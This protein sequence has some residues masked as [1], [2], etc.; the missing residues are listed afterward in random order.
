MACP[1]HHAALEREAW[2]EE[3]TELEENE[4]AGFQTSD[5]TLASGKNDLEAY[6][7][8]TPPASPARGKEF[9]VEMHCSGND[10]D[11][12]MDKHEDVNEVE[13]A[14]SPEE[15]DFARLLCEIQMFFSSGSSRE[16]EEDEGND[17]LERPQE[18]DGYDASEPLHEAGDGSKDGSEISRDE[19]VA[20]HTKILVIVVVSM[21]LH[22]IWTRLG[23]M[24]GNGCRI[25]CECASRMD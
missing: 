3:T 20:M 21:F 19:V 16:R 25:E 7:L 22:E 9:T 2:T 24:R 1:L 18:Q 12:D 6:G 4:D 11:K 23:A 13:T 15:S 17:G 5:K 14:S 8:L 10:G